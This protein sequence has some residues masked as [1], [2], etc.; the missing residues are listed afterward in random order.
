MIAIWLAA[1]CVTLA[2]LFLSLQ[3]RAGR[4]SGQLV[5]R[6]LPTALLFLTLPVPV[7]VWAMIRGFGDIATSGSGGVATIGPL[8]LAIVR[9]SRTGAIV[10]LITIIAAAILQTFGG[11]GG[12]EAPGGAS[13][14]YAGSTWVTIVA[15]AS[16][17]A[18]VPVE[19]LNYVTQGIARLIMRAATPGAMVMNAE[20]I[21]EVSATIA[22]QSMLALITGV[23]LTVLVAGLGGVNLIVGRSRTVW[24]PLARASTFLLTAAGGWIAWT[25]FRLS[26]DIEA[27]Q[28]ALR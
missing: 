24:D 4:G 23:F 9:A 18:I 25:V 26:A 5:L 22:N 27:F 3:W 6:I 11:P 20:R 7:T 19:L 13:S 17:L 8:C 2:L 15:A 10:F 28:I 1:A 21:S 12:A 14:D 16:L